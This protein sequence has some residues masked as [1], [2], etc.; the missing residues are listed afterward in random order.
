MNILGSIVV[1]GNVRRSAQ[2]A[3]G[4]SDDVLF[5]RA[6]NWSAGNIP[7]HRAMSNNTIYADTFDYLTDEF[8]KGYEGSAE[9][10]GLFNLSL[11][12]RKGRLKDPDIVD[13]C[14]GANPLMIAA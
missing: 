3:L 14:E 9:P 4:D 13:N 11:S 6:K 7:N 10:Y 8:W 12:Q 2:I 1:A 5:L